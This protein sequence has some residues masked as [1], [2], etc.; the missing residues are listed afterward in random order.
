MYVGN[1]VEEGYDTIHG[2]GSIFILSYA[3]FTSVLN[4]DH[5]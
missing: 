1:Y 2:E 5:V 4:Y 3:K